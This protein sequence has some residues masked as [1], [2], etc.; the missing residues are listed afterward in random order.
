M[1][2]KH[3]WMRRKTRSLA[4]S[5]KKADSP[6]ICDELMGTKEDGFTL[7]CAPDLAEWRQSPLEVFAQARASLFS[8]RPRQPEA[9]CDLLSQEGRGELVLPIQ[10]A[11]RAMRSFKSASLKARTKMIPVSRVL[12]HIWQYQRMVRIFRLYFLDKTQP[13]PISVE[14]IRFMGHDFY[15]LVDG[16][17]RTE[18]AKMT[19]HSRIR[20]EVVSV[21]SVKLESWRATPAGLLHVPTCKV[22]ECPV[23]VLA[24]AKWMG[25]KAAR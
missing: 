2:A 1:T 8:R 23:D 4:T 22:I 18:F 19:G 10:A 5:V 16:N 11:L 21:S 14:A 12:S 15:D 9:L 17:H 3:I 6:D 13:P 25:V 7:D 20:A 24:A